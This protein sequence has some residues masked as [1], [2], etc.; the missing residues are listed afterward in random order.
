MQEKDP[1]PKNPLTGPGGIC[2]EAN[3]GGVDACPPSPLFPP[4][5]NANTNNT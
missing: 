2:K 4:H 5:A 1:T 3:R